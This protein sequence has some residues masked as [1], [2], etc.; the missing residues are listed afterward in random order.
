MTACL[1]KLFNL[2]MR[3]YQSKWIRINSVWVI[4]FFYFKYVAANLSKLFCMAN[5]VDNEHF[6]CHSHFSF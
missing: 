3:V 4:S 1:K 5:L 6:L 2:R